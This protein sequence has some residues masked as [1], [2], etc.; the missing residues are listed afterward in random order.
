MAEDVEMEE[1]E[2]SEEELR[3]V[4]VFFETY[5]AHYLEGFE[6]KQLDFLMINPVYQQLIL[7]LRSLKTY[8][9]FQYIEGPY[10]FHKFKMEAGGSPKKSFYIFGEFHRDSRL[11]CRGTNYIEFYNYIKLLS[12][13]SPSFFDVYVEIPTVRAEYT[14]TLTKFAVQYAIQ[15]TLQDPHASFIDEYNVGRTIAWN[16]ESSSYTLTMIREM[17]SNCIQPSFRGAPE[18]NIMRIHNIDIRDTFETEELPAD[19]SITILYYIFKEGKTWPNINWLMRKISMESSLILDALRALATGDII[20]YFELNYSL[21]KELN[22]KSYERENIIDFIR[23]RF[24][25][26]YSA[27]DI[28]MIA[29]SLINAIYYDTDF[30]LDLLNTFYLFFL[31]I[32]VFKADTYALARIFKPYD[33][34]KDNPQG[35]FQPVESKNIIIY[36][37]NKHSKNYVKFLEYLSTVGQNVRMP[38]RSIGSKKVSCVK[39][40]D[41][42]PRID[43]RNID[44]FEVPF[45]NPLRKLF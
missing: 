41:D 10:T 36:A 30:S 17:F 6:R 32:D 28:V 26:K 19:Y 4:R 43:D 11:H 38:Y 33:V 3:K 9:Q 22:K 1:V 35:A 7:N 31:R 34:F 20:K 42:I 12:I 8:S 2:F 18:C 39:L 45:L 5:N 37:G 14:A 44:Y 24:E 13:E 25:S 27:E 40:W 23:M 16:R 29:T 21:N 15:R